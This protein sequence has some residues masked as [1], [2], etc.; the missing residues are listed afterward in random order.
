M[1]MRQNYLPLTVHPLGIFILW[2]I[3]LRWDLSLGEYIVL[4]PIPAP[5]EEEHVVLSA[6]DE[7][8]DL[9]LG[10]EDVIYLEPVGLPPHVLIPVFVN[11][12]TV[13][14]PMVVHALPDVNPNVIAFPDVPSE[15]ESI[16]DEPSSEMS[17]ES[18]DILMEVEEVRVLTPPIVNDV[19]APASPEVNIVE[20]LSDDDVSPSERRIM[21]V[22]SDTL[23]WNPA[24]PR[25]FHSLAESRATRRYIRYLR[26]QI[27]EM[28]SRLRTRISQF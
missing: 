9:D 27:K 5:L 24:L 7:E 15:I 25:T 20:V 12:V 2:I 22:V 23:R 10:D 1:Q 6:I 17:S 19:V 21:R 3:H 26:S 8:E 11:M 28:R 18:V 16:R 13:E 4:D 14:Q